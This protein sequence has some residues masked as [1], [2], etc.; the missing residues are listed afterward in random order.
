VIEEAEMTD[1]RARFKLLVVVASLLTL[2]AASGVAMD[3]A[4]QMHAGMSL[5]QFSRIH[6][7]HDPLAVIEDAIDLRPDQRARVQAILAT[8]QQELNAAWLEAHQ[9]IL[10]TV[11]EV[12]ADIDAVLDPAQSER[13]QQL[14][15]ELHGPGSGA[16]PVV[17]PGVGR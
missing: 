17:L 6:I 2:G 16:H 1:S 11:N 15:E 10:A 8:H 12:V 9:R 5:A 4:A 3:R 14:V 13:F 7:H